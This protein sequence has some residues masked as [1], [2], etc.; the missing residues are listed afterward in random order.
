MNLEIKKEGDFEYVEE[1][2]GPVLMLLHGLF[3]ALS[4]F[5]DVI[6][7]FR[8]RYTV[9]IP[10]MPIYT[11]PIINTSVKNLAKHIE[12]FIEFKGYDKPILVG[13]SLGGHVGLIYTAQHPDKVKYLVLTGSSGLY[14][15]AFGSSFPRKSDYNYIKQR[16]EQTFYDP[17]VASKELVDEVFDL[18]QDK[19]KALR[20]ISLAKSAIRHNMASELPNMHVP[21]CLI[22][23]RND[24]ITPPEV[25][26]EFHKSLPDSDL[27]WLDKCGH[28]PMME[29][30]LEFNRILDAW[31][32][33]RNNA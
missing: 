24:T 26:D 33:K 4:N 15:N 25:A 12:A 17:N 32:E 21:V 6:E 23:G 27:F 3:G 9:T 29:L 13:N 30:P 14:E 19:G 18:V 7:H 20:S 10:L 28:A 5:H 22:W 11:M 16:V 31:L 1:G 2:S 8:Q